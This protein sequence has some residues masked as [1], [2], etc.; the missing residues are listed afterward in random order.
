VLDVDVVKKEWKIGVVR[1][2]RRVS[3]RHR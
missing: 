1:R 3:E 2:C